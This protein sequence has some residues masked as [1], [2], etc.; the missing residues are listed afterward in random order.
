VL[1]KIEPDPIVAEVLPRGRHQ[2][3]TLAEERQRVGNIGR[4]SAP[5]LVHRIDQKAQADPVHVLGQQVLGE[6]PRKRH[7]V[8]ERD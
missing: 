6:L 3:R 4:A 2:R 5:P 7:Q 1:Q 8:V